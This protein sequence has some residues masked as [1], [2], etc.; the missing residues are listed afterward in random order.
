M[1][2][3]NTLFIRQGFAVREYSK[4]EFDFLNETEENIEFLIE[5]LQK[6][7]A[8]FTRQHFF[9][10][11]HS[12]PVTEKEWLV[13]ADFSHRGYGEGLWFHAE[14]EEPKIRELD[15]YISGLVRQ[16]NRLELFTMGSCDGHGKRYA[17]IQ[18]RPGVSMD[19]AA[20]H[21]SIISEKMS[22]SETSA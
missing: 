3:W 9:L 7:G 13:A 21:F 10:T 4:N 18:F 2:S 6:A 8:N 16:L 17:S 15:L 12:E 14:K 5:C 22:K 20:K 11:I 19:K 1:K